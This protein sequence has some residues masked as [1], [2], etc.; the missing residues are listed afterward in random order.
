[1]KKHPVVK[2]EV[3]VGKRAVQ[4]TK[5]VGGTVRKEQVRVER[6]R[7]TFAGA[8]PTRSDPG[9]LGGGLGGDPARRGGALRP[10]RRPSR[11]GSV[12]PNP[13]FHLR[14]ITLIAWTCDLVFS[15]WQCCHC[16][17]MRR[18]WSRCR[19]GWRGHGAAGSASR[20]AEIRP[21]WPE[22]LVQGPRTAPIT[23]GF[24]R[25]RLEPPIGPGPGRWMT[26]PST[27]NR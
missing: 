14:D 7:W 17:P 4:D 8:G 21:S 26:T 23:V 11:L 3:A 1:M 25:L 2:E 15:P 9:W 12:V 16:G 27:A 20:T 22:N 24:R 13:R 6:E 19:T 18:P 10:A 5:Q